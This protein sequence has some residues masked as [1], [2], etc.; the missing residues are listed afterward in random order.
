MACLYPKNYR[1]ADGTVGNVTCYQGWQTKFDPT[2]WKERIYSFSSHLTT[3][4]GVWGGGMSPELVAWM[5]W[6][7]G[8]QWLLWFKYVPSSTIS[9]SECLVP[10]KSTVLRDCRNRRR[11]WARGN[12]SL[13]RGMG[14]SG[15]WCIP[16][17]SLSQPWIKLCPLLMILLPCPAQSQAHGTKQPW[18]E[19]SKSLV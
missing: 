18:T 7:P 13:W 4:D 8:D 15:S 19:P 5:M 17:C 16:G 10:R 11:D 9:W 3:M 12:M 6:Q 14:C 1:P 2:W